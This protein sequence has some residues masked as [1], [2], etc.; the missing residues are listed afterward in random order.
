LRLSASFFVIDAGDFDVDV[1][2]AYERAA[3][4]LLVA[5]DGH[6]GTT[7]FFHRVTVESAGAGVRVAVGNCGSLQKGRL[8][9]LLSALILPIL[10]CL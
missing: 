1:D 3:D 4:L 5:G 10:K 6:S 2:A 7:A 9:Y 8:V